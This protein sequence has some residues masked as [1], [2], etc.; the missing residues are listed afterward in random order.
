M[1]RSTADFMD[2]LIEDA[3]E[4][5]RSGYYSFKEGLNEGKRSLVDFILKCEHAA[6]IAE[7]KPV[8]PSLGRLMHT[9]DF[10][11]V[12]KAMELGGAAGVS[13]LTEPK[14]FKGSLKA[15]FDVKRAVKI[16]VLMKDIF[17]DPIQV[18]TA[19]KLGADAIL[20]IH[21]A[22][23]RAGRSTSDMIELAHSEGLE[24]LLEVQD[25]EEFRV[26]V[27]SDADL[28]GINNRDLRT[29]EVT[30][31]R[32]EIILK[33]ESSLGKIVVSESG[34]RSAEDIKYLRK[35][36]ARAFLVGSAIM[37]A[38]DIERKVRELVMAL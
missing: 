6:V 7:I 32:T 36:G 13:V 34:I 23:T 29:L 24:V 30:L 38:E 3:L 15:L 10:A 25:P 27:R 12:A 21:S 17:L 4:R 18:E 33:R 28:I 5:V 26:A 22:I 20:L 1:R 16:P 35:C 19:S 11:G 2:T 14:R 37:L 8:S 31:K 9:D